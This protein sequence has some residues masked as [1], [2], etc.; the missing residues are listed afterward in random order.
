MVDISGSMR[1]KPLE[2]T[3]SALFASLSKLDPQD[4]FNVIAFAGETF[5]FSSSLELATSETIEKVTGWINMN[6][7]A[8]GG[9]NI[10]LPLTQVLFLLPDISGVFLFLCKIV[11]IT[12]FKL[13]LRVLS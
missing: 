8:G 10:L 4:L 1:G 5:I 12:Y 13:P 9:T 3:K 2:N 6:F 7:V 11:H